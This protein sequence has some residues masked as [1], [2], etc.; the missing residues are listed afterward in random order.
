MESG[1]REGSLGPG[2]KLPAVRKLAGELGV[3]PVT[4]AAAYRALRG[5]GLVAT[6]GR[7][8]TSVSLG[9]PLPTRAL[10]PV[11]PG[12][13]NLA[14]GN[15]DPALLPPLGSALAQVPPEPRLYG[16]QPDL[17]PLVDLARKQFVADGIPAEAV[18][19]V[20]GAH[21]GFERVLSAHLRQ[22]DKIAMED[23]GH[24]NLLDLVGS[25][26]LKIDPVAVDD[27][28][29]VPD[30]LERALRSG[31]QA[32]V[33]V[34]RA[35]NPT[36]AALDAQRTRDLRAV[37]RRHPDTLVIE[38]DHS[39]TIA[40]AAS[41]TLVDRRLGRWAVVRTVSKTLGP[42]L[43]LAVMAGDAT[44]VARVEGR[45]LLSAG[46]VSGIVQRLVLALWS[47]P[48]VERLLEQARTTYAERRGALVDALQAEGIQAQ[49]RSGF[50]VWIP[51]AHER[52]PIR[53]LLETGWAVS[54]GERFR[55]ASPP[56][57]RVTAAT[58]TPAE[59]AR[60]ASDLARA[61]RPGARGYGG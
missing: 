61:L 1:I 60:F 6:D 18:T 33:L 55:V 34:P 37:L 11:P 56:G 28:G 20:A 13:R 7:R 54:P 51:V 58:L 3:S 36:G 40:G 23:P 29:L 43:R 32:V 45:R 50:N 42:D 27:T 26:G 39:A 12:V 19:V 9:P 38:D 8:G 22:G 10:I 25:L 53:L 57:L 30:G 52:A 59:A 35:Q 2:A 16:D 46:W 41:R 17:A 15:P 4:V 44:T 5:R 47:D 14:D 21:D 49:G 31:A 24:A 48:E